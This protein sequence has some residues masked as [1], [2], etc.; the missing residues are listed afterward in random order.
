M[1][2]VWIACVWQHKGVTTLDVREEGS[3]FHRGIDDVFMSSES[4]LQP[5]IPQG[6][7][8][9]WVSCYSTSL[10]SEIWKLFNPINK[11]NEAISF[12]RG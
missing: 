11:I 3:V 1:H 5:K 4:E 2:W 9:S 12:E 10:M 6:I 8:F 7:V